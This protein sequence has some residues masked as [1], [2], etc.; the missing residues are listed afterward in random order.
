LR[1]IDV[2]SIPSD[3]TGAGVKEVVFLDIFP[4]DDNITDQ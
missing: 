4:E 1:I 2:S 3:P